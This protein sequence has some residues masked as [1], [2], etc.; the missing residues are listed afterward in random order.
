MTSYFDSWDERVQNQI[1]I[2]STYNEISTLSDPLQK[3][4]YIKSITD[5]IQGMINN[6]E[7]NEKK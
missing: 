5:T 2:S 7:I 6:N 1:D 3:K 4:E